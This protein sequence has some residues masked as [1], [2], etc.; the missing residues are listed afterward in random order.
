MAK[1]SAL[2]NN[3]EV[4]SVSKDRKRTKKLLSSTEENSNKRECV[5]D[6][7]IHTPSSLGYVPL[8]FLDTAPA[9]V[10]LAKAKG[11]DMIAVT[12]YYSGDFIDRVQQAAKG[13]SL[14]VIPGTVV[15]CQIDSCSEVFLACL[16]PESYDSK[17]VNDFL[18]KLNVPKSAANKPTFILKQSFEEILGIIDECGG[19]AIPSTMDKTPSRMSVIPT[20]VEKYGFRVFDLSYLP[21]TKEYF[22]KK[23]PELKF[24]LLSFSSANALAQVGNKTSTVVMAGDGFTGLKS[25]AT[26][27]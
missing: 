26:R 1:K 4:E 23:W 14:M 25:F 6:L 5:L 13:T 12:D 9:L 21:E 2:R 8:N 11:L 7:R 18:L 3:I 20:L 17:A 24:H 16:F 10:R 27:A 22:K 15:R 19:I